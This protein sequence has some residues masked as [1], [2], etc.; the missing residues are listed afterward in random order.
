MFDVEVDGDIY[1]E[2]A[3]EEPGDESVASTWPT[4]PGWA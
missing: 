4:G 2:S 1:A 3:N